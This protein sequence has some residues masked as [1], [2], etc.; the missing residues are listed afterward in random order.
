MGPLIYAICNI[1]QVN[2]NIMF[3]LFVAGKVCE[4]WVAALPVVF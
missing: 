4:T 2:Q 3:C 1:R